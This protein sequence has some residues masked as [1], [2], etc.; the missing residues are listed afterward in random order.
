MEKYTNIP[1]GDVIFKDVQQTVSEMQDEIV[2][3]VMADGPKSEQTTAAQKKL[4]NSEEARMLAFRTV[5]TNEGGKT[6]GVDGIVWTP[7]DMPRI[8]ALLKNKRGYKSSPVRRI[9]IPKGDTGKTRPL[10]IPT[11]IDR[12]WQALFNLALAPVVAT[13]N[14]PRSY[15]FVKHRACGDAVTYLK[16]CL[17]KGL[18][19]RGKPDYATLVIEA[20]IKGFFDNID[21]AWML[22]NTPM[23]YKSFLKA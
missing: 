8:A 13:K 21:H 17:N 9:H 4:I 11:M 18:N 1:Y 22:E 2:R 14:C 20:D 5:I 23:P 6:P 7:E 15:G 3:A 16:A 10:G 19:Q 12:A